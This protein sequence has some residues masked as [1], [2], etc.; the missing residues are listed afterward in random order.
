M[1]G[2]RPFARP[3]AHAGRAT[4]AWSPR[5]SGAASL[6]VTRLRERVGLGLRKTGVGRSALF[7][8][9]VIYETTE[10]RVGLNAGSCGST[11]SRARVGAVGLLRRALRTDDT[12]TDAD[13]G[14][15]GARD[16]QAS[17]GRHAA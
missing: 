13:A 9:G 10:I 12:D 4:K 3:D 8:F 2:A 7:R 6:R 5:A 11:H 1:I 15:D 17:R 16:Y 14:R